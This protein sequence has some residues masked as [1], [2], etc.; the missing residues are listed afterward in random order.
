MELHICG[1]LKMFHVLLKCENFLFVNPRFLFFFALVTTCILLA[2]Y[3]YITILCIC[4]LVKLL[5]KE[6]CRTHRHTHNLYDRQNHAFQSKCPHT[7]I[8]WNLSMVCFQKNP[9]IYNPIC[10]LSIVHPKWDYNTT[11]NSWYNNPSTMFHGKPI[12]YHP[13]FMVKSPECQNFLETSSEGVQASGRPGTADGQCQ[14][15]PRG[16]EA[17]WGGRDAPKL[18]DFTIGKMMGFCR[19]LSP[20]TWGFHSEIWWFS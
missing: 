17:G 13:R 7:T 4:S 1:S 9:I 15:G 20:N 3:I 10:Q 2:I 5:F 18:G 11:H 12:K 19:D 8:Y 14:A 6:I 16:G